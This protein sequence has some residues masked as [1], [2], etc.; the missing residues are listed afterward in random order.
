MNND[1]K[2]IILNAISDGYLT[3]PAC[4]DSILNL[5]HRLACLEEQLPTIQLFFAG[6]YAVLAAD[7]GPLQY[8]N[9]LW[10][11]LSE[12]FDIKFFRMGDGKPLIVVPASQGKLLARRL[13]GIGI[14]QIDLEEHRQLVHESRENTLKSSLKR[15]IGRS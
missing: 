15:S 5:K 11:L 2:Q 3:I 10:A 12:D 6:D 14:Q 1:H 8:P 7:I 9:S 13:A 4:R